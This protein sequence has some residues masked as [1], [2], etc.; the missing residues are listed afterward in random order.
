MLLLVFTFIFGIAVH[1]LVADE[2][3]HDSIAL[4][5]KKFHDLIEK[6]RQLEQAGK[7]DEA[8]KKYYASIS[9]E[10]YE[11]YSYYAMI[12]IGRV[13]LRKKVYPAAI[14]FLKS[15]ISEVENELAPGTPFAGLTDKARKELIASKSEAE[16]MLRDAFDKFCLE[17]SDDFLC[18][19]VKPYYWRLEEHVERIIR[20]DYP[21]CRLVRPED[22]YE[23]LQRYFQDK[24]RDS[25]PGYVYSD[26]NG[27]GITDYAVLIRCEI[28][29]RITE[30]FVVFMGK[31][32]DAFQA[33]DIA[34]WDDELSL[35][36]LFLHFVFPG[37][38]KAWDSSS[39]VKL[40]SGGVELTLFEAASRVYYWDN[41]KFRFVQT[42]D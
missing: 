2:S 11:A 1:S 36:N 27:D 35:K 40:M 16:K 42:S 39:T 41:G 29:N 23:D 37:T 9:I 19:K 24:Y 13:Y 25:Y 26:F 20:T 31:G 14:Y 8:L 7:L 3:T 28:S 34:E 12:D 5:D 6:G 4:Q 10:R 30:K 38:I 18:N 17:V 21:D 22:L 33:I 32:K 15:Y